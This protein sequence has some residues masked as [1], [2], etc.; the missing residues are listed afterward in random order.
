M[1]AKILVVLLLVLQLTAVKVHL[2]EK[3]WKECTVRP[4]KCGF[5]KF[6]VCGKTDAGVT[7]DYSSAC[8][9]C[10]DPEVTLIALGKC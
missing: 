8:Y 4:T 1:L 5:L 3:T 6:A 9:A 2:Q 10:L 7:K